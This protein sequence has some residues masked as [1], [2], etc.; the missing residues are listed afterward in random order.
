MTSVVSVVAVPHFEF[1]ATL[2]VTCKARIMSATI[3]VLSLAQ[4]GH[5][6][7]KEERACSALTPAPYVCTITG[8]VP[9]LHQGGSVAWWLRISANDG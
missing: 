6:A 2:P 5:A 7:G 3:A 9:R 8:Q 4:T 1:L